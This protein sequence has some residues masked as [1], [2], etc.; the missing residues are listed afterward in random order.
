MID[1][2]DRGA[3]VIPYRLVSTYDFNS[4]QYQRAVYNCIKGTEWREN[5]D[6]N[7]INNHDLFMSRRKV[8]WR[9]C[10]SLYDAWLLTNFGE[11]RTPFDLELFSRYALIYALIY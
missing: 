1:V 8:G 2:H 6:L 11:T 10:D 7:R 9:D 5:V 4:S 3:D